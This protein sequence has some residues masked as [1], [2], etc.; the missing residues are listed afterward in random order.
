MRRETVCI[1]D[2]GGDE[3]NIS[4]EYSDD[5]DT[6]KIEDIEFDSSIEINGENAL[7]LVAFITSR[8]SEHICS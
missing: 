2:I 1:N 4:W 5:T 7:K 6:F 8:I 3:L